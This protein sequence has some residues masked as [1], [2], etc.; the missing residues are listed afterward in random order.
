[1]ATY[2]VKAYGREYSV[3]VLDQGSGARV[4]VE[5]ST[6]D[7]EPAPRA[8]RAGAAFRAAAPRP[9]RGGPEAIV[10]PIPGLITKVCVAEGDTVESGHTVV[11]LEAMK[12]ENDIT[13]LTGGTVREVAVREGNEVMDG[14]LL[15][16]IG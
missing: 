2:N 6:F 4:V 1:M 12:M 10:A 8:P 7:V 13:T 15:V 14:Q 16:R 3:E 9:S 5:G 11:R